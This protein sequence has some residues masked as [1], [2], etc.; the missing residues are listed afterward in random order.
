[1]NAAVM[2]TRFYRLSNEERRI[3]VRAA[4][5]LTAA[6]IAVAVL[7]FRTAI[8]FGLVRL[9][10]RSTLRPLDYVWAVEAVAR[11]LP[12]R[13]VCIQKGLAVQRLLRGDGVDA[14]L[15]YGARRSPES[16]E[17]EAHVW[18]SVG[19]QTIIGGEDAAG[20]PEIARFP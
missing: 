13:T 5:V 3:L 4:F 7:P 19:G 14:V 1:M 9:A 16:G 11:R 18:V 8:R 2:V 12:W 6:A 20:L 10:G 17:L 15:H